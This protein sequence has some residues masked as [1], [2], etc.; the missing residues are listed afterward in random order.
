MSFEQCLSIGLTPPKYQDL[1]GDQFPRVELEGNAGTV[2]VVA[3]EFADARGAASTFSPINAW[4]LKLN[5]DTSVELK[6][7][8]GHTTVLVAQSGRLTVNGSS[9]T[10]VELALFERKGDSIQIQTETNSRVLILTGEPLGEPVVGQGP[11]VMN[12]REEIHKAI[13]DYQ[14]GKMGQLV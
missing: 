8:A 3:G 7:P 6:V 10:A 2:R 11:F 12:T 1:R 9:M 14:V 13:Q 5:T 4:D